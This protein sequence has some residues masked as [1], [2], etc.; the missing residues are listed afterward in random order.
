MIRYT[1]RTPANREALGQYLKQCWK[2]L[3]LCY[4]IMTEIGMNPVGRMDQDNLDEYFNWRD[5]VGDTIIDLFSHHKDQR[6]DVS[7]LQFRGKK[8][9]RRKWYKKSIVKDWDAPMGWRGPY[10]RFV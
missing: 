1:Q 3:A 9:P 4:T 7:G 5:L 8:L 2:T 10:T 6:K